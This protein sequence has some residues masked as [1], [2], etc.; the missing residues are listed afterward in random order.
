MIKLKDIVV[1]IV[2]TREKDLIFKIACN[3]RSRTNTAFKSQNVRKTSETFDLL[4]CS[5]SLFPNLIIHQLY[6]DMSPEN[7]GVP[8]GKSL[9][10]YQ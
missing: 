3:L 8:F 6:G 1:N 9:T 10:V 2:E 5:L 4:G 7:Y